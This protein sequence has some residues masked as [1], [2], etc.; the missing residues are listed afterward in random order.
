MNYIVI[1]LEFNQPFDFTEGK[2]TLIENKCPV[3][4]IQIGAVKLDCNFNFVEK[5]NFYVKPQLYTR[6]HPFVAKITGLSMGILKDAPFFGEVYDDFIKFIGRGKSVL[7]TW[8]SDDV[9]ELYK[10]I[11]YYNLNHKQL[12]RKFINVQRLVGIHLDHLTNSIS[13]K[14]AVE[15]FNIEPDV[16]FHDALNDA[17]Y[18][19]KIFQIVRNEN[20]EIQTFNLSQLKTDILAKASTIN[21]NLL[22]SY[23]GNKLRKELTEKDKDAII[24]IYNAGRTKRFDSKL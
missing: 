6:M 2:K 16:P 15:A 20:M 5:K 7:C 12:T 11:L 4:V 18:T 14:S 24:K 19:A 1:D 23:A 21:L 8:G 9:K 13:L 17:V 22:F 3:E 10:N